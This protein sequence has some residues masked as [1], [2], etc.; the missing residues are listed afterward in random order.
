MKVRGFSLR[1][2]KKWHPLFWVGVMALS[3]CSPIA[4]RGENRLPEF[5]TADDLYIVDCLL[6]PQ[7]RKLG[8]L[9]YLGPRRPVRTTASDCE[10]RGGEYVAYDRADYRSALSVWLEQAEAGDPRAENYVGEIFEKGLGTTPDYVSAAAWYR[11]A[12]QQGYARAR[13][14]LGYLYETGLGVEKNILTAL[15][16]YRQAAGLEGE[17]LVFDA[18]ARA[19]LERVRETLTQQLSAVTLQAKILQKQVAALEKTLAEANS[20]VLQGQALGSALRQ[21]R[22]EKVALQALLQRS[23]QEQQTLEAQLEGLRRDYPTAPQ[24]ARLSS[25]ALAVNDE[26]IFQ[27]VNFG[28]YFAVII[29]N[30]DYLYLDDLHSP[31]DDANQLKAVLEEKYGFTT[32]VLPNSDEKG[33]LVT[34]NNLADRLTAKDNLLI[35]YAGHGNIYRSPEAG[36]DR[37]YWLPIEARPDT[38]S[39]WINHTVISDHLDRLQ[40]RSILVVADSCYAGQLGSENASFLFGSGSRVSRK[41]MEAGL[42]YR[43]RIVISSGSTQPVLDGINS[44]HSVFASALLEI[45][46]S[47]A[48]VLRDTMLFSQLLLNVQQR[49]HPIGATAIPEMKPLRSAGHEGGVFYFVPLLKVSRQ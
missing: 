26:R 44:T 10:L 36:R 17:S 23:R 33:I 27:D 49:S 11:R 13:I 20:Q 1:Q 39:H 38:I 3:G 6:P 31:M 8:S 46:S 14:N 29:A 12:A 16:Y 25:L 34:L 21:A 5:R 30:E 4:P 48:G 28:R 47:N 2:S 43:A 40:A 22:Q 41:S 32:F 7:I 9:T 35:Y 37:G 45:L 19:E 42:S 15:N 24:T 18:T